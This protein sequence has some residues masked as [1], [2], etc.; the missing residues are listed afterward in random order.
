[1]LFKGRPHI[2][3]MVL[4]D[5]DIKN[6]LMSSQRQSLHKLDPQQIVQITHKSPFGAKNAN[7]AEKNTF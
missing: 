5:K 7:S 6:N 3:Q 4:L 1:M 2:V